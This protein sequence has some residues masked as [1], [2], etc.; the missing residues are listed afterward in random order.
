LQVNDSNNLQNKLGCL[1][2]WYTVFLT[3]AKP[4]IFGEFQNP[5][6]D[7]KNTDF[8]KNQSTGKVSKQLSEWSILKSYFFLNKPVFCFSFLPFF[9]KF[10]LLFQL[11]ILAH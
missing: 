11:S 3:L 2:Y 6:I 10:F 5:E 8:L 7:V 1:Y 4:V 9:E